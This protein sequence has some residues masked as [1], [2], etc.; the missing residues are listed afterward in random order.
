MAKALS[1][2]L[3]EY[4]SLAGLLQGQGVE[5]RVTGSVLDNTDR[6]LT[7]G[8]TGISITK[9]TKLSTNEIVQQLAASREKMSGMGPRP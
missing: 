7:L 2:N 1:L 5:L 6:T 4:P 9:R 8:V 3:D